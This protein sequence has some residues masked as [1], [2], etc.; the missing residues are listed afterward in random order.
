MFTSWAAQPE[1][2][3]LWMLCGPDDDALSGSLCLHSRLLAAPSIMLYWNHDILLSRSLGSQPAGISPCFL[4][5]PEYPASLPSL[6]VVTTA[7]RGTDGAICM[8][9]EGGTHGA[10]DKWAD[11]LGTIRK[12]RSPA[13]W[14]RSWGI[15]LRMA[16]VSE[17]MAISCCRGGGAS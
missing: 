4:K 1:E 10:G 5:S 12:R 7:I 17:M 11:C 16:A 3:A 13:W 8:T 9:D 15:S 14:I 2:S 6:W